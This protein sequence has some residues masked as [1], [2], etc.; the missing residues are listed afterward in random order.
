VDISC[1]TQMYKEYA[2]YVIKI[3]SIV[4][5]LHRQCTYLL[6]TSLEKVFDRVMKL[7]GLEEWTENEENIP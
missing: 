3:M 2:M 6:M 1:L 4:M 7:F 5:M